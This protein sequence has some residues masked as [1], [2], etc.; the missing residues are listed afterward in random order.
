MPDG[1]EK[2][3]PVVG[4]SAAFRRAATCAVVPEKSIPMTVSFGS[5]VAEFESGSAA[6]SSTRMIVTITFDTARVFV[7]NLNIVAVRYIADID[8]ETR[9]RSGRD[10]GSGR[11]G[12]G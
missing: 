7:G 2:F 12:V 1:F 3:S 4:P 8:A 9:L 11:G 5:D 10:R 6:G